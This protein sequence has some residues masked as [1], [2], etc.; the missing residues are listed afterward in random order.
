MNQKTYIKAVAKNLTCSKARSTEFIGDLE[1]DIA[2]ALATGESWEKIEQRMGIPYQIAAEF[3]EG[4]SDSEL[5]AGKKRKRCKTISIV[6]AIVV[7][8]LIAIVLIGS[9]LL[10]K[11]APIGTVGNLTEQE[12]VSQA[13]E[14]VTLL[15]ADDYGAIAGL[16]DATLAQKL[17]SATID[18]ARDTVG[19]DWGSF[20]SFGS[21][22]VG[23]N[24]QMGQSFGVIEMVAVYENVTV[25]YTMAFNEDLEM[26]AL[27]MK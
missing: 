22:R 15:D 6:A 20:E 1:A 25:T 18:A 13:E 3:N 12:I 8:L 2:E 19:T 14:I 26:T 16:S 21:A 5:V 23:K 27:Y 11:S 24:I 4:L 10:P 17:D 9:W 7:V